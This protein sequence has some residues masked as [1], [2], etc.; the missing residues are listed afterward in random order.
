M[1]QQPIL[2]QGAMPVEVAAL[3]EALEGR[4]DQ[5]LHGFSFSTGTVEGHPLVVMSAPGALT[6]EAYDR[7]AGYLQNTIMSDC[8]PP[9]EE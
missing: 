3:R 9:L 1:Q 6:Q 5:T 8:V 4:E 7:F 2:I